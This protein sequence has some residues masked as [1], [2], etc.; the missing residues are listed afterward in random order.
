MVSGILVDVQANEIVHAEAVGLRDND[1]K[2]WTFRVSREVADNAEEPFSASHLRQ[3]MMLAQAV[4]VRY[5][6]TASG[7]EAIRIRDAAS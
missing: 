1:G 5:R 4:E 6:E 3:H 7:L 2:M